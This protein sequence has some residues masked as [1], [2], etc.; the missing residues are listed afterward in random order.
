MAA[1]RSPARP[2]RDPLSLHQSLCH[3]KRSR[4]PQ[5]I[6]APRKKFT[7]ITGH[8]SAVYP[9]GVHAW[10]KHLLEGS[11]AYEWVLSF[12]F[13]LSKGPHFH[14]DTVS[15]TGE[16]IRPGG[17][18]G[19]FGL[20][21]D[22]A[23]VRMVTHAMSRLQDAL[24]P[25]ASTLGS[26][27]WPSA[28]KQVCS[29][30]R[31]QLQWLEDEL[32]ISQQDLIT[33][34]HELCKLSRDLDDCRHARLQLEQQLL[35]AQSN[36]FDLEQQLA[37]ANAQ[38]HTLEPR[39][40]PSMGPSEHAQAYDRKVDLNCKLDLPCPSMS[41]TL[42]SRSIDVQ[43]MAALHREVHRPICDVPMPTVGQHT[44]PTTLATMSNI[45]RH[46]DG[47]V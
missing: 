5:N 41:Q 12:R 3:S 16:E 43:Y 28:F 1:A 2:S 9:D 10:R 38:L 31:V 46:F 19:G 39:P 7:T 36:L 21:P 4:P 33:A 37:L 6:P 29:T 32:A 30:V 15:I 14:N 45:A 11:N 42:P 13:E 44:S 8:A 17:W 40:R 23:T 18:P 34:K 24:R 20:E 26:S 35:T 22:A 27:K 25:L 47:S